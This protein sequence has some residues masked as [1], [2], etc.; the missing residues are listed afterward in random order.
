[1]NHLYE[2]ILSYISHAC[3]YRI[4]HGNCFHMVFTHELL[5]IRNRTSEC[6]EWV[7]FLIQTNGCVNTIQTHFSYCI[8]FN[9][10]MLRLKQNFVNVIYVRNVL[11]SKEHRMWN[12]TCKV[13]SE[14]DCS[15]LILFSFFWCHSR[16]SL[17]L[18]LFWLVNSNCLSLKILEG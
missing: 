7:R 9:I 5:S 6:N 18:S 12:K 15:I 4:L 17:Q 11:F 2:H 1:M 10:C 14:S 3:I 13:K 8:V 16:I